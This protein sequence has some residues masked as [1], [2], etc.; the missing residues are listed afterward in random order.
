MLH[1]QAEQVVLAPDRRPWWRRVAGFGTS[2]PKAS[3]DALI[4]S[5]AE[6][7]A[8]AP[9]GSGSSLQRDRINPPC[10]PHADRRRSRTGGSRGP[11][12]TACRTPDM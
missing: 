6:I 3:I 11:P 4:L 7:E 2:A 10:A 12:A 8:S 9:A 5:P 1:A